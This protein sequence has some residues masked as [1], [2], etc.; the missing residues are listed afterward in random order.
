MEKGEFDFGIAGKESPEALKRVLEKKIGR[1]KFII[2]GGA[3]LVGLALPRSLPWLAR[4]FGQRYPERI[5]ILKIGEKFGEAEVSWVRILG[6]NNAQDV[7]ET[8]DFYAKNLDGRTQQLKNFSSWE[9]TTEL[10][11][12]ARAFKQFMDDLRSFEGREK[13]KKTVKS[14][15]GRIDTAGYEEHILALNN[16]AK[17]VISPLPDGELGK[18]FIHIPNSE[19]PSENFGLKYP[20]SDWNF[21]YGIKKSIEER[22][23]ESLSQLLEKYKTGEDIPLK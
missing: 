1:R 10:G 23:G 9:K 2:L 6:S 20:T 13:L 14:F 7:W 17:G 22:N 8:I 15:E 19:I 12:Y 11:R 21:I 3:G 18:Y 5:S 16:Y 4:K